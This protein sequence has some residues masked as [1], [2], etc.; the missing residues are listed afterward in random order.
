MSHTL[1]GL[2]VSVAFLRVGRGLWVFWLLVLPAF[3]GLGRMKTCSKV[4][5]IDRVR[6][7][8]LLGLPSCGSPI[9]IVFPALDPMFFCACFAACLSFDGRLVAISAKAEFPGLVAFPVCCF[10]VCCFSTLVL[11]S[12]ERLVILMVFGRGRF[13]GLFRLR[14]V[15]PFF[16]GLSF[17]PSFMLQNEPALEFALFGFP[18]L[19][20]PLSK[21]ST[22]P[23]SSMVGLCW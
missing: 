2:A 1:L 13:A 15:R 23:L 18:R 8:T 9:S 14:R 12:S 22:R 6:G 10:P 5:P 20:G 19:C 3:A 17:V 7:S 21:I 11:L 4:L 16:R